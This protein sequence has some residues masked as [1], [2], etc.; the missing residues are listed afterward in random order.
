MADQFLKFTVNPNN[1]KQQEAMQ[2]LA[3]KG[4][5]ISGGFMFQSGEDLSIFEGDVSQFSESFGGVSGYSEEQS[6]KIFGVIDTDGNGKLDTNEINAFA[7]LGDE[8]FIENDEIRLDETDIT[9][10]MDIAKS[11]VEEA[12]E[13]DPE[14]DTTA[15]KDET[16]ETVVADDTKTTTTAKPTTSSERATISDNDASARAAELRNAMAGWGTDEAS[17]TKILEESGYSSADILKIM[18]SF[19]SSYGETLMNDIQCDYSG[20]AE[21][22]HREV[23][24][25]AASEEARQTLGWNKTEDIPEE[26]AAKANEF[27]SQLESADATGYMK[28]FDA[29][30]D[31]E[32]AQI[33]VACD[34]LHTDESSV[35]RVT[36]DR[37]WSLFGIGRVEDHY[38][39]NM[40]N[41]LRSTANTPQE[42]EAAAETA[43]KPQEEAVK[44]EA[45]VA[46]E[47]A[48]TTA[49]P[50]EESTKVPTSTGWDMKTDKGTLQYQQGKYYLDGKS[51]TYDEKTGDIKLNET[52]ATAEVAEVEE[53]AQTDAKKGVLTDE[54]YKEL[55]TLVD[56]CVSSGFVN[57]ETMGKVLDK[58]EAG[59][60]N[61]KEFMEKYDASHST[62][63][64]ET[65]SNTDV[66]Y[67]EGGDKVTDRFTNSVI[68]AYGGVDNKDFQKWI[69]GQCVSTYT[70]EYSD[71]TSYGRNDSAS[72]LAQEV[73]AKAG[74]QIL[75]RET[76]TTGTS[77]LEGYYQNHIA[78][79][80]NHTPQSGKTYPMGLEGMTQAK[81]DYDQRIADRDEYLELYAKYGDKLGDEKVQ[82]ENYGMGG[83]IWLWTT[84]YTGNNKM[85]EL[86]GQIKE[87]G[88]GE[89]SGDV[90]DYYDGMIQSSLAKL[91]QYDSIM[92]S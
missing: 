19:E 45:V 72:L 57:A 69:D 22:V 44:Q 17:V 87:N 38:V 90:N 51:C 56:D 68:E 76:D 58:I 89:G 92:N 83:D 21:T 36:E 85:S 3:A 26:V 50:Q 84:D 49:K 81:A 28:D 54:A 25:S 70:D 55:S 75:S 80:F 73:Y 24:Y 48:T 39:D 42:V 13:E 71:Y 78:N 2:Q 82:Y 52:A 66:L 32:K 7:S 77:T 12:L 40:I 86:Y 74:D 88:I 64:M 67:G 35:S 27:Y 37:V 18:D 5:G 34:M 65:F 60:Y 31:A 23:L 11:N 6:A 79:G 63:F 62:S 15:V 46:N 16:T 61:I 20:S 9:V 30:P 4:S 59:G 53:T 1:A 47:T 10:L 8:G 91:R 14:D 33:L 43:A 41:A 29:L